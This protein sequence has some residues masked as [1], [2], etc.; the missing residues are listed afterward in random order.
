LNEVLLI[1]IDHM[2]AARH[3]SSDR[4]LEAYLKMSSRAMRC[5]LEIY[6]DR[7]ASEVLKE[8]VK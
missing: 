2:E 4:A 1:A 5:A 7:F 8:D 3:A 6:A